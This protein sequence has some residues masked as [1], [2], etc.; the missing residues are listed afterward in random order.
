MKKKISLALLLAAGLVVSAPVH[1]M[2]ESELKAKM[3]QEYTVNGR[4]EKVDNSVV[5]QIERYFDKYEV[6]S[7]DCDYI[8]G[9][10]DEAVELIK[11][12]K[13]TEWRELT[14]SEKEALI[15]I[16]N[17][18]SSKTSVKASLSKSGEL[19]IYEEDGKTVFTKLSNLI[20]NTDGSMSIVL[21]AGAA[22]SLVGLL[23][24][25]KKVVKANA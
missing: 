3:T 2:T 10:I 7:E 1:A 12:G 13:A 9:K 25:T 18:I 15:T 22:I 4:T 24:I 11:K 5:T 8:A 21:V 20:K 16:V 17:D 19:T 14:S 23:L 6:S